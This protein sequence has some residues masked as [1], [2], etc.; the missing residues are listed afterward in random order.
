MVEEEIAW[1]NKY[2]DWIF[3]D[4]DAHFVILFGSYA[5]GEVTGRSDVDLCIVSCCHCIL[6]FSY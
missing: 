2:L 5:T 4:E 6:R 1:L 3:E